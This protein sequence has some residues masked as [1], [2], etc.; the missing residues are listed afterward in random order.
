MVKIFLVEDEF[1]V[2][3][4][5]KNNIPWRDLGFDFCGEAGDGELAYPKIR[6]LQ[7]DIVITDI[8]MPFMDGLDLSRLLKKEMP[9]V[10]IMILSGFEEFE[11]AKEAI[12]LGIAEYLTKPV[13]SEELIKAVQRLAEKVN[14]K[15]QEGELIAKYE[16]EMEENLLAERR[17]LFGNLVTGQTPVHELINMAAG[18]KLELSAQ[19]Y[20]IVLLSI[21]STTHAP[22]EYSGRLVEIDKNWKALDETEETIVFDRN[23]EG[24]A[25]LFTADSESE[26][27]KKRESYLNGFVKM[28]ENQK[29]IRYYGACG[30]RVQRLSEVKESF[31]SANIVFL[32]RYMTD[33]STILSE[34]DAS[35]TFDNSADEEFDIRSVN[36]KM[37]DRAKIKNFMKIGEVEEISIFVDAYFRDLGRSAVE[38]TLFRQYLAMDVYF[39]A[40]ECATEMKL[41][42]LNLPVPDAASGVIN[43]VE[44][45]K[46]YVNEIM[47]AVINA[48]NSASGV[49]FN[50]I[51]GDV[52]KYI[53]E[54]Y[55]D[56]ELSLNSIAA[57]V[58]FSPS[59][60][61]MVFS[62]E[63]GDTLIHYLTEFRMNKAKELLKCT[64]KKSSIIAAEVGYKNPHYFSYLFRK[65]Q[66][67]TPTAFRGNGGEEE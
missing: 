14:E 36:P 35:K 51:I 58:N 55:A 54:N 67:V 4:G 30:I 49:R 44:D 11:Y 6:E 21:N 1:V 64:C 43:T 37:I 9:Q 63:T 33:D 45:A 59:Y 10:E 61:S 56:D 39:A 7:P 50:D 31:E 18:M 16:R 57:H 24:K 25:L 60:L 41:T 17:K 42:D 52:V 26:L 28:L 20:Q 19:W 27:V 5:I 34:A 62:Q 32:R 29:H 53:E 12:R 13:S 3:E 66:G 22:E 8:R 15:K 47:K 40:S 38:S 48:R 23:F 65:T 46:K 2:R